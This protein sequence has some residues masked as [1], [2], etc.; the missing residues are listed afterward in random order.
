MHARL[1]QT[2]RHPPIGVPIW[3]FTNESVRHCVPLLAAPAELLRAL[4]QSLAEL[5]VGWYVF[6]AQAVLHWG[7]PRFTE[8]ID[9]TVQLG[10]VSVE[11]VVGR[12]QESGFDLRV[13][14]TPAF[15]AQT[16]V[17]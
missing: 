8:D 7:R 16:R 13:E 3:K 17:G 12:L 10:S 6:G 15:I 5:G 14:G 2:G 4:S 9:I 11:R 1:P